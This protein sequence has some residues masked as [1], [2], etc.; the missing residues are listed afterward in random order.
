VN[1]FH[2]LFCHGFEENKAL[3]AGVLAVGDV[4]SPFFAMHLA[5]QATQF[6][7]KVTIYTNGNENL[8]FELQH[9]AVARNVSIEN[10]AITSISLRSKGPDGQMTLQFADGRQDTV[11]FLAHK[12]TTVVS[13]PFVE[14]LGLELTPPGDLKL[15]QPFPETNVKGCFAAGDCATGM[16]SVPMAVSGGMVAAAGLSM[17]LLG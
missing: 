13:G 4:A 12:P 6:S 3:S 17:Q 8:G 9:Q 15:G 11:S 16:K 1:I 2:C 10:G 7:P 5:K 14:Q